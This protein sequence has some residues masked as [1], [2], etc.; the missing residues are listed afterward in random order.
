MR[1]PCMF[2]MLLIGICHLPA[3]VRTLSIIQHSGIITSDVG[4]NVT[5]RCSSENDG[6]IYV[7][8]YQQSLGGKL[9]IISTRMKH[10]AQANIYPAYK[11]RFQV[12][13]GV[14]DNTND[15]IIRDVR[16]SDSATYYCVM[17]EF[18]AIEF[19]KGVFLHVKTSLS[20]TQT[21]VQQ[22]A[23]VAHRIGEA[24]RLNCSV[25]TE[26]CEGDEGL[27]WFRYGGSQPAIMH[28]S[29]ERCTSLKEEQP[30][31]KTCSATLAIK[32]VSSTDSGTYYCA[33]ASCG[34]IVFGPGTRLEIVGGSTRLSVIYGLS[35]ALAVSIIVLLSLMFVVHKLRRK[36]CSVCKGSGSKVRSVAASDALIQDA[37]AVHYA[38]LELDRNNEQRRPDNNLVNA[39]VYSR[40][41]S[42]KSQVGHTGPLE[43]VFQESK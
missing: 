3:V 7:S 20:K 40:V 9:N 8:W 21:V 16:L 43:S 28:P 12:L 27:Y 24:V 22:P 1:P 18:T 6:I 25:H 19:G 26:Q 39:C 13:A 31:R 14:Q 30:Q 36:L 10:S 33:L 5:L 2:L 42:R 32:S 4:Q 15:L 38:A 11:E 34:E 29:E 17:L 35:A 23:V 37:D 41:N